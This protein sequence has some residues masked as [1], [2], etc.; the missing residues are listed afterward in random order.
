MKTMP[1][2][3]PAAD[4]SGRGRLLRRALRLETLSIGYNILEA[5]VAI[6]AGWIAG[7]IALVGFGFD[8][9]IETTS[10]VVVFLRLRAEA[11]NRTSGATFERAER[12]AERVV[13]VTLIALAAYVLYESVATLIRGD[14]P[15]ESLVGIV[16]AAMS[17]VLMP[18]LAWAKLRTG[19]AL[20]S[21]ALIADS[22]ETFVCTYLSFTLL[23]GLGLN[24]AVGWW[25][26]DPVAALLMVPL[27][28]REGREAWRGEA[29]CEEHGKGG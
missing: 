28:F 25:W 2:S 22:K 7:S 15:A 24:A 8:S 19:R 4:G 5:V 6:G 18:F 10:A 12:R 17:V 27:I 21:R 13:G 14:E 29:C 11:R 1:A 23:V 9:A 20:H 16:L 26:A 3:A